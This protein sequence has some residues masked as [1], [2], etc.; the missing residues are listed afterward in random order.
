VKLTQHFFQDGDLFLS[1]PCLE[2]A[3]KLNFWYK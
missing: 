1:L 2:I 3:I